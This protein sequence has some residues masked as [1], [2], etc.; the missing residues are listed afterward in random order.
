[1]PGASRN[2]ILRCS[3]SQEAVPGANAAVLELQIHWG[4]SERQVEILTRPWKDALTETRRY[5][6]CVLSHR[7]KLNDATLQHQS[8]T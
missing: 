6:L 5:I 3:C 4:L 7:T 2:W 1:M 8:P